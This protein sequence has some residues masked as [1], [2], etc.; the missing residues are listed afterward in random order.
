MSPDDVRTTVQR[1]FGEVFEDEEFEFS[2][3]LSRESL[4][5]WDSLGHIRL[6]T[7]IEEGL[8][9]SFTIEEIE[10]CTSAGKILQTLLT[11]N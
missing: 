11:R 6:I 1:I 9:V 8:N 2:D 3:G 10:S 7:A 5:S 4:K